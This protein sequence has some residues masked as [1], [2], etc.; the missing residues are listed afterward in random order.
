MTSTGTSKYFKTGDIIMT[1]GMPG[2]CAYI[3]ESGKVEI[4]LKDDDGNERRFG[5]RSVG[6]MIGEMALVDNAKRTATIRA[7]EDCALLEISKDDFIRRLNKAD[8]VI[9][10]ATQ[11][12]LT[13]YRDLLAHTKIDKDNERISA[14]EVVEH[15]QA[16][17]TQAVEHVKIANEFQDA[18]GNGDISLHYQPIIS[19]NTGEIDGFEALMR[20]NHS[21]KG[22]ISPAVF[23]PVIEETGFIAKASQWAF[24]EACMALKRIEQHTNARSP[25]FMSVNFSSTDFTSESFIDDILHI[26]QANDLK[27][28]QMHLE[29]TERLLMSQTDTAKETLALCQKAGLGISIDDFGTGYSSLSYLHY[30]PIDTLKIDQSFVRDLLNDNNAQELVKSIVILAKNLGMNVIAEGVEHEEEGQRLHELGCENAQG[31]FYARPMPE[32]EIID[33][34]LQWSP[35]QFHG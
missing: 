14:A 26:I 29:I 19:L 35:I 27:P 22:F 21:E 1:Q 23:I 25:L 16:K 4:F 17:Q 8:P 7:V 31:Y 15:M 32:N 2:E 30:F 33:T 5:T 10:M 28:E 24:K 13:R 20:W 6:A 12:I 34:I 9:K 11:V 3:I 18:L